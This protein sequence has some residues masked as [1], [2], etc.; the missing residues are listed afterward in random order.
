M[1]NILQSY[2]NSTMVRLKVNT[3]VYARHRARDFNSTMVRLKAWL[4]GVFRARCGI[5]IPLWYD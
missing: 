5:S 3:F 2:F 1:K 4:Y